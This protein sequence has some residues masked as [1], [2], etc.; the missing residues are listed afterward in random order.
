MPFVVR[1]ADGTWAG[2]GLDGEGC[3][4]G[5]LTSNGSSQ[6]SR[7]GKGGEIFGLDVC[8]LVGRGKSLLIQLGRRE[9]DIVTTPPSLIYVN[10]TRIMLAELVAKVHVDSQITDQDVLTKK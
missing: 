1:V 7:V 8:A 10:R 4:R 9:L 3:K 2:V 5:R 6:P